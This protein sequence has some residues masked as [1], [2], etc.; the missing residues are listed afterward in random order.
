MVIL[1]LVI[2]FTL[3]QSMLCPESLLCLTTYENLD[4][5][6]SASL[7]SLT[8]SGT[9]RQV[10]LIYE[11]PQAQEILYTTLEVYRGKVFA[12]AIF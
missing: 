4:G 3:K 10:C 12:Q 11:W 9:R 7:C 1:S 6:V 8:L 2:I 5:L